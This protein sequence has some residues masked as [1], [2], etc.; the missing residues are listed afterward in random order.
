MSSRL[1]C[2]GEKETGGQ[3]EILVE[4]FLDEAVVLAH[5]R[6]SKSPRPGTGIELEGG[7]RAHVE[8]READ[9]FRLRFETGAPV[10]DY[11]GRHGHMPLPPYIERPDEE[12]DRE[13][14]QTVY[15]RRS[16]RGGGADGGAA[17]RCGTA[18]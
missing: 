4:R 17:F 10:L 2:S 11:L 6:A 8:G 16:G 12:A 5:V 13:R 14:Y 18:G 15:A 3:V 9:L 1:A 7:G